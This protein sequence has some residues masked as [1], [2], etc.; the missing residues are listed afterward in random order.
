M[1]EEESEGNKALEAEPS[2]CVNVDEILDEVVGHRG[3]WQIAILLVICFSLPSTVMIPIYTHSVP[4]FRCALDEV[5]E[6]YLANKL[7]NTGKFG[8]ETRHLTFDEAARIVGP[9]SSDN[10]GS[11]NAEQNQF[12]CLRFKGG[13]SLNGSTPIDT[14]TE[15]CLDGYVY[16]PLD[17]QYPS[18]IV[19]EWD[20]VC[21]DSWKSP[22]STSVY[23]FGMMV[24]FTVGGFLGGYLGRKKTIYLAGLL[25]SV[26]GLAVTFAPTYEAYVIFRF[27]LSAAC[28]IN[29]NTV[30]VLL[31]EITNAPNRALFSAVFSF[32]FNFFYSVFHAVLAMYVQQWRILHLVIMVPAFIGLLSFLWIPE[33]PRFLVSQNRNREAL[34]ALYKAYKVNSICKSG[35]K[36]TEQEFLKKAGYSCFPEV[37]LKSESKFSCGSCLKGFGRGFITPYRNTDFAKR[38]IITTILFIGQVFSHFGLLFYAQF[39]RGSVYYVAMI[40]A[41]ASIPGTFLSTFLYW[42]IKSRKKPLLLV[43]AISALI[44]LIG[45]TY[46]VFGEPESEVPLITCSNIALLLLLASSNMMYIYAPELFPSSIRAEGLGNSAGIG[47]VGS[48]I[49]TFV[50][51]LDMQV[52]HGVPVIIYGGS[53]ILEVLLASFLPDTDGESLT[54]VVE[55]NAAK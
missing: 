47:R 22:F 5:G 23:M 50:N 37:T 19:A 6:T 36:L 55:L 42:K 30:S 54:D 21:K 40:N 16:S 13:F 45:G 2:I 31:V 14:T 18:T 17:T 20:L 39:V 52:G 15:P 53:L 4:R 49:C 10:N 38:S 8:N 9:W 51:E 33:S 32:F 35:L 29:F 3:P 34:K 46:T 48:M 24:G 28:T 27:L 26:F 44:L 11:K 43:Y 7:V 12:G 41:S 25:E 1:V